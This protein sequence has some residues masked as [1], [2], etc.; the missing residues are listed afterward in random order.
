MTDKSDGLTIAVIGTG[1]GNMRALAGL[2]GDELPP[3]KIEPTVALPPT[4]EGAHGKAWLCDMAEG[5]RQLGIDPAKDGA[6]AHWVVEAPWAH[7]GWHSYS[8]LVTHLRPISGGGRTLFY[9]DGATHELWV[10][11]CDPKADRNPVI[12]TGIVEALWLT[13][14]NF[15]AQFIEITDDLARDRV[16]AVVQSICDGKL[17]PDTDYRQHWIKLFGDNMQKDRPGA[18]PPKVRE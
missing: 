14:L 11:A 10:Y 12:R 2:A 7:P 9:V 17:S 3:T 8:I 5:H 15:A 16:R 18:R 1:A 6:I 4:I 13:P